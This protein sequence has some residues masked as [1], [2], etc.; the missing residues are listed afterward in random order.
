MKKQRFIPCIEGDAEWL[1]DCC[2]VLLLSAHFF[3]EDK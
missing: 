1:T 3:P 2:D